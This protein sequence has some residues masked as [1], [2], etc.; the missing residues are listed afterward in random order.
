MSG[1]YTKQQ[2]EDVARIL[3]QRRVPT[4][5]EGLGRIRNAALTDVANDFAALFAADNPPTCRHRDILGKS[6]PLDSI[7]GEGECEQTG[8][9]NRDQFLEACGLETKETHMPSDILGREY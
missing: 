5:G 9:F 4:V 8:G 2:Y 1:R 6:I 3:V 7:H